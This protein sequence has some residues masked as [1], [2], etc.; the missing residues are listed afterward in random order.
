MST[1]TYLVEGMT[2]GHCAGSV[3]REVR[4]VPGVASAIVDLAAKTVTVTTASVVEGES[5]AA[6]IAEAGYAF[7]GRA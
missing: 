6:A 5:I 1:E 3:E 4:A 7:A 2:C